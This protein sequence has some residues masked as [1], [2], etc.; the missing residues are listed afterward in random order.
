MGHI[1]FGWM[2]L[3]HKFSGFGATVFPTSE[4]ST[5]ES[6]WVSV[7]PQEELQKLGRKETEAK[8]SYEMLTQSLQEHRHPKRRCCPETPWALTVHA[9]SCDVGGPHAGDWT[10]ISSNNQ[11]YIYPYLQRLSLTSS[12]ILDYVLLS[13]TSSFTQELS[14]TRALI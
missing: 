9:F 7:A 6:R 13:Q 2:F 14:F 10:C 8:H 12:L 5:T 11:L 1:G 4:R 3:R